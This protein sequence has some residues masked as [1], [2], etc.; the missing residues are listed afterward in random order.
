M[1]PFHL[2]LDGRRLFCVQQG[3]LQSGDAVLVL[4]PFAEEM[5][6]ARRFHTLLAQALQGQG[7]ASLRFDLSMTGDSS[8][9]FRDADL[10]LWR[11]DVAAVLSWL[12]PRVRAVHVFALRSAA[13]LLPLL[14]PV[15]RPATGRVCLLEPAQDGERMLGEFLRIKVARSLFEG[16]RISVDNLRDRLQDGAYVEVSGYELSPTLF[17]QLRTLDPRRAPLIEASAV[18]VLGGRRYMDDRPRRDDGARFGDH[19]SDYAEKT[20]DVEQ[21]WTND[22][23]EPA[24][25]VAAAVAHCFAHD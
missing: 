6:Q 14:P 15:L 13:L 16:E 8:G 23:P 20:L 10:A 2:E 9:E 21:L 25:A 11:D 1:Q 18:R 12:A 17:A 5:N 7:F 19:L 3:P 4:P 24:A 22:G